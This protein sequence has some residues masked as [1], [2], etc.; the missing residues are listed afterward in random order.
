M[1]IGNEQ[2]RY[3][4]SNIDE[5]L[6]ETGIKEAEN[7]KKLL[8]EKVE[9]PYEVFSSPMKRAINTARIIFEDKNIETIEELKEADLGLFEGKNYEELKN[10]SYYID[11]LSSNGR[12][13][14]PQG[15]SRES[16]IDRSYSGFLKAID[17]TKNKSTIVIVCHGGNI[18]GIMSRLTKEDYYNFQVKNLD[19]YI[20]E[21][22]KDDKRILNYAYDRISDRICF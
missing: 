5:E 10:E 2:K 3:I 21:L 9:E 7:I 22:E 14:I 19:G 15:E 6:S 8:A 11:W 20:L 16:F 18:M 13:D 1:T 12:D 17:E 4:G